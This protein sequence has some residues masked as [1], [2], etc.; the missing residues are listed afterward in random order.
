MEDLEHKITVTHDCQPRNWKIYVDD[1]ICLG[2]KG[3]GILQHMKLLDFQ[4]FVSEAEEK[5]ACP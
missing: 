5:P 2:T 4:N 3:K 1:M